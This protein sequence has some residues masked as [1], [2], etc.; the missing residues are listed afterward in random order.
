MAVTTFPKYDIN[1]PPSSE[2]LKRA[3]EIIKIAEKELEDEP[4][5]SPEETFKRFE[6]L[7][8]DIINQCKKNGTLNNIE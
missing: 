8:Q 5:L 7:R 3:E 4:P 1:P 2:E 6:E